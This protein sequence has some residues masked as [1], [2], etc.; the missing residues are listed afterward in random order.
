MPLVELKIDRISLGEGERPV[1]NSETRLHQ[2]KMLDQTR[3]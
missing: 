1:E 2:E 3:Y